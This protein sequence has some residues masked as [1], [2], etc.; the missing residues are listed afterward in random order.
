MK[1][2]II[3]LDGAD[4][5]VI[6]SLLNLGQLPTFKRL[7]NTGCHGVLKSTVPPHSPPA[8][9]SM[10]TGVNPGKHGIFDFTMIDEN[11][12]RVPSE[13]MSNI[14]ALPIW[15]LLN[16]QG[17]STGIVNLPIHYPPEPVQG[18]LVCGMITPGSAAVFSYP[19]SLSRM[20]G[21]LQKNWI[22]CEHLS[23]NDTIEEFLT[24]IKNKTKQQADTILNLID[25]IDTAFLMVVFDGSDKMQH[26]FWKYWDATHPRHEPQASKVLRSAVPDFYVDFDRYLDRL[27]ERFG[28]SNVFIVSDHGF[29]HL[30]KYFYVEQW[31]L[32]QGY[33]HLRSSAVTTPRRIF[34]EAASAVWHAASRLKALKK[35]I[36]SN[37]ILSRGTQRV[38]ATVYGMGMRPSDNIDWD[39]TK[40]FF[41]GISSQVL[42]INLRGREKSGIICNGDEYANL[43]HELKTRLPQT[44]DPDSQCPVF[45]NAYH[46]D[47]IYYGPRVVD[48]PDLIVETEPGYLLQEGFPNYLLGPSVHDGSDRSGGHRTEGIFIANGPDIIHLDKPIEVSIM[49]IVPTVLYLNHL[50]IPVY[51]D[52]AVIASII[53]DRFKSSNPV[54]QT[55]AY[56][57][58]IPKSG[59]Y[60]E[61]EQ[62]LVEKHL[63]GLGYF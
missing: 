48:A 36:K 9:A 12:R 56:Q 60:S 63:K 27:L 4:W 58:L 8:W 44:T 40:V 13:I 5:T 10:I 21:N 52:G 23:N 34:G 6:E 31:L 29:T 46:R 53:E 1:T 26:F 30:S 50:P 55:D 28:E 22:I 33:L 7:I 38:K 42:R 17:I 11:Y 49:D 3:G 25:R 62:A 47:E 45:S 37:K 14:G 24:E 41:G 59:R 20:I 39:K 2:L 35:K 61:E 18:Y 54:E 57:L 16:A 32:E 43:V 19:E 15:R 51:V